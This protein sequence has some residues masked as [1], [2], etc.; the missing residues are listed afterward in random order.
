MKIVTVQVVV[1]TVQVEVDHGFSVTNECNRQELDNGKREKENAR[2]RKRW[3]E[4][5]QQ[6][7]RGRQRARAHSANTWIDVTWS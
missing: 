6:E 5:Q 3:R 2:Q 4:K 7:R 1:L